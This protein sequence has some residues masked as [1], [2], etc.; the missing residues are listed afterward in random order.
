M[1]KLKY[2]ARKVSAVKSCSTLIPKE[3]IEYVNVTHATSNVD[4]TI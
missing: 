4:I 3:F 1:R 2:I